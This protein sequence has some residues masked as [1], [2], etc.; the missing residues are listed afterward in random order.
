MI[1]ITES[2][3]TVTYNGDAVVFPD[4]KPT[5]SNGRT[6][7]P[8]RAIMER[9]HLTVEFDAPAKT[10]VASKDSLSIKMP[11]G[12]TTAEIVRN[13]ESK[14]VT[15]DEPARLIQD[16]T[17]VPV[18][19]LAESL[20]IKV[21]WNPYAKEVVLIDTAEWKQEIANRSHYLN[22][23]FDKPFIPNKPEA[24]S[25]A[26]NISLQYVAQGIPDADGVPK[27]RSAEVSL[28]STATRVFDGK[29]GGSFSSVQAD[30]SQLNNIDVEFLKLLFSTHDIEALSKLAKSH[31][32]EIDS[33]YDTSKTTHIKSTGLSAICNDFEQTALAEQMAKNYVAFQPDELYSLFFTDFDVS[34]ASEVLLNAKSEWDLLEKL[35][36]RDDML[37]TRSVQS[38]DAL[39]KAYTD[40]FVDSLFTISRHWDGTYIRQYRPKEAELKDKLLE[41]SALRNVINGTPLDDATYENHKNILKNTTVNLQISMFLKEKDGSP[42]KTETSFTVNM[43]SQPI[44]YIEGA[45]RQFKL[46]MQTGESTRDF[47]AKRDRRIL[48][49]KNSVPFAELYKEQ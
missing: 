17:Y 4:A 41:I 46:E 2:P 32:L 44:P 47:E 18:R 35:I 11:L 45:T 37:Y 22:F 42:V 21:N 6:L 7:V 38:I 49:P 48:L 27:N 16:R 3:I 31:N 43:N 26:A 14:T 36:E 34:N 28:S 8:A 39:L 10:V 15:L 19:F 40:L 9:A 30:F 29:K 13:G 20:G 1:T 12:G 25:S 33:I 5:V 23:L 24:G